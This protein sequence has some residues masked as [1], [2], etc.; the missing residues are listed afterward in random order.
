MQRRTYVVRTC[1]VVPLA[2]QFRNETNRCGFRSS[3]WSFP[4]GQTPPKWRAWLWPVASGNNF[5]LIGKGELQRR[6]PGG[7]SAALGHGRCGHAPPDPIQRLRTRRPGWSPEDRRTCLAAT[8][9]GRGG[10]P[11]A[12]RPATRPIR[13][14][15]RPPASRWRVE[16]YAVGAGRP[17]RRWEVGSDAARRGARGP[18]RTGAVLARGSSG[19]GQSAIAGRS[20]LL[21]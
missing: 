6:I 12:A 4:P 5:S 15:A 16:P 20:R 3:A 21:S 2:N 1:S 17:V 7:G 10:A 9:P 18:R 11:D 19:A 8:A 14:T 13:C